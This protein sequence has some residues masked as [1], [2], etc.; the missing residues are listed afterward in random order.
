MRA[1]EELRSESLLDAA[2]R[3]AGIQLRYARAGTSLARAAMAGADALESLRHYPAGDVVDTAAGTRFYYHAHPSRRHPPDEHGHFHLFVYPGG[4]PSGPDFF[5]LA[6]LSLDARGQALRWFTTNRWVT[7]E[8]WREAPALLEAL[9]RFE[10]RTRGRLA[11]VADWLTAMVRLF[12]PQIAALVR[13]RDAVM[14]RQFARKGREG[15]LED[16]RLDVVSESGLSLPQR[17]HQLSHPESDHP[18][19]KPRRNP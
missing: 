18:R 16:R 9:A 14:A 10:V 13:R 6:A 5:H 17:L 11:P 1:E 12:E 2:Q 15:A 8:R 19:F 3:V 7:G 4:S